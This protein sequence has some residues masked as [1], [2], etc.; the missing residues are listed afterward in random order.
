MQLARIGALLRD[1]HVR[2]AEAACAEILAATPDD[3]AATHF[4]QQRDYDTAA[5]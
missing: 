3:A 1:G 5:G 2:E 4:M